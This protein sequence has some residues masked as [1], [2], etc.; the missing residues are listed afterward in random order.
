MSVRFQIT[1]P[2]PMIAEWRQAAEVS[3]SEL[4]R[5]TMTDIS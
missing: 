3:V 4:I 2:E 1:V 5:Q